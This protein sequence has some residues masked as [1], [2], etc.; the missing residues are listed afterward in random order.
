MQMPAI[1]VFGE[2]GRFTTVDG[3]RVNSAYHTMNTG[4]GVILSIRL[5]IF[6]SGFQATWDHRDDGEIGD[7][8][9]S[10]EVFPNFGP[11]GAIWA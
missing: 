10:R 4:F 8:G 6:E 7:G 9:T 3:D 1:V 5:T 2:I 11:L